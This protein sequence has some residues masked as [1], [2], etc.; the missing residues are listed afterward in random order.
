MGQFEEELTTRL[1]SIADKESKTKMKN[2]FNGRRVHKYRINELK[3]KKEKLKRVEER[4]KKNMQSN[5]E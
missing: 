1:R 3:D 2:L 5:F 4:M